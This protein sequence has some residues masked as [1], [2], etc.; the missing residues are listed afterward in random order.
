ML[1]SGVAGVRPQM[2]GGRPT[3]TREAMYLFQFIVTSRCASAGR[4][5]PHVDS[6]NRATKLAMQVLFA[7]HRTNIY[8]WLA[9]RRVRFGRLSPHCSA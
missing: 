5:D 4:R 6:W 1:N 3:R 9:V 7:R 8:R 2:Q